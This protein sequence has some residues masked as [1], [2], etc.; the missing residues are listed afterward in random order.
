MK[1]QGLSNPVMRSHVESLFRENGVAADQLEFISWT[2]S[3]QE[4]LALYRRIDIA[5]ECFPY[6]G[7]TT[8]CEALWMGAP[9]V[10]LMGGRHAARVGASLLSRIGLADLVARNAQ[11]YVEIAA[12]LAADRER[13]S[14]LRHGMRERMR[15]S[16]LC[17]A[18][19]FA[20]RVE[21]AYRIMWRGWCAA[22]RA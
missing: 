15:A 7:T 3:W 19:T 14:A 6:N 13:L 9:M 12:R 2:A 17:D 8:T 20:R 5:L 18:P 1:A 21:D 4:H 16:P 11:E 22:K 10:G